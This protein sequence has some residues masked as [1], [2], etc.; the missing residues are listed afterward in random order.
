MNVAFL[1]LLFVE[2][3]VAAVLLHVLILS[4]ISL[5]CDVIRLLS[6]VDE[7]LHSN[8]FLKRFIQLVDFSLGV[9]REVLLHDAFPV[10]FGLHDILGEVVLSVIAANVLF[11]VCFLI[12]IGM[13]FALPFFFI[14][15]D[16]N[17]VL[18]INGWT[19]DLGVFFIEIH[20]I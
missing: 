15:S 3:R 13:V 6:T 12:E 4:I 19:L 2:G 20:L 10:V 7:M 17:I 11:S 16:A 9:F 5:T 14:E 18:V 1:K 8:F